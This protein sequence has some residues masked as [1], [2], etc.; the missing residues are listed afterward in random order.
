MLSYEYCE[1]LTS[2]FIEHLRWL[3]VSSLLVYDPVA[4]IEEVFTGIK[5]LLLKTLQKSPRNE[6]SQ[7]LFLI[8]F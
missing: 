2:F 5:K 1:I 8:T 7:S 6:L 3:P 4:G